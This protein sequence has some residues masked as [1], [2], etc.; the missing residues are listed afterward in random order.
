MKSERV[1]PSEGS[2]GGRNV[3]DG[4]YPP[5]AGGTTGRDHDQQLHQPLVDVAGGGGLNNEDIFVADRLAD[6]ERSLLVRVVEGYCPSDLDTQPARRP[7]QR[8]P[9]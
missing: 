6:G 3:H 7:S 1:P 2:S 4:R 8:R 5:R 9:M